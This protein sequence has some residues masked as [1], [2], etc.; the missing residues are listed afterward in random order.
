M[1]NVSFESYLNSLPTTVDKKPFYPLLFWYYRYKMALWK[2]IHFKEWLITLDIFELI[3]YAVSHCEALLNAFNMTA[4]RKCF[5]VV[6]A[7][8]QQLRERRYQLGSAELKRES[9]NTG[10]MR[11]WIGA[12]RTGHISGSFRALFKFCYTVCYKTQT[13]SNI[14]YISNIARQYWDILNQIPCVRCG[15]TFREQL[16]ACI[17][18][19]KKSIYPLD[20]YM[21]K[22]RQ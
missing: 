6:R 15:H 14:V 10:R 21:N 11:A 13:I 1:C 2:S 16:R 12:I 3:D 7:N 17:P 8:S 18:V 19:T 9:K 4:Y 20:R 22:Q 5:L